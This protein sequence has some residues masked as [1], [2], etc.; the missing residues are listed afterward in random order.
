MEWKLFLSQV[1]LALVVVLTIF[2]SLNISSFEKPNDEEDFS[3]YDIMADEYKDKSLEEILILNTYNNENTLDYLKTRIKGAYTLLVRFSEIHCTSCMIR[4]MN[5]LKNKTRETGWNNIVF[6]ASYSNEDY[7][8][9]FK[10]VHQID[11]EIL[12]VDMDFLPLDNELTDTPYYI[13][14][15][16][17]LKIVELFISSKFAE[18]RTRKFFFQLFTD[19]TL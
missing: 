3:H 19:Y 18:V 14:L 4:D 7:F 10:R 1:G 12:R 17:D 15:D 6:T 9:L 8:H 13:L 16:Q 11:E 5:I 2:I